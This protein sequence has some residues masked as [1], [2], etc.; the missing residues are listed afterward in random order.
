MAVRYAEFQKANS[1]VL[2]LSVDSVYTHKMWQDMELSKMVQGGIPYPMLSD[3]GG[4]IGKLYGVYDSQN[5]NDMRGTFI[6]DHEGNIQA[7]EVLNSPVGR[8]PDEIL[9]LLKAF[10]QHFATQQV[11]P[12]SW[13]QGDK[14]L[15][16]TLNM[17]GEIWKE[18]KPADTGAFIN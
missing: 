14:T 13:H 10:Q 4:S 8:N 5:G 18:W 7:M 3:R 11:M 15:S 12:A 9:R 17:A 16:P 2:T 1:E 6:I